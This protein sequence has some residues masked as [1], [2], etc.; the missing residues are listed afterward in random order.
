MSRWTSDAKQ[1]RSRKYI[2]LHA[3]LAADVAADKRKPSI[4]AKS[5]KQ[6][7]KWAQHEIHRMCGEF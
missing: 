1:R 3:A 7:R 6:L 5:P 4:S 2:E